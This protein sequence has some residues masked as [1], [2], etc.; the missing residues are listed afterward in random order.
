MAISVINGSTGILKINSVE[1]I[2]G[3]REFDNFTDV[4]FPTSNIKLKLPCNALLNDKPV[5]LLSISEI[6]VREM[7][8]TSPK[9][10]LLTAKQGKTLQVVK[11][12]YKER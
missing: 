11:L 4:T 2:V 1:M 7:G 10:S 6:P 5:V 12:Q 3:V 9:N 8:E